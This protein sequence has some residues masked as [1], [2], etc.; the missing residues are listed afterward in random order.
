MIDL[1]LSAVIRSGVY[2][3]C[4]TSTMVYTIGISREMVVNTFLG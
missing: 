1:T 2:R 4:C 3:R